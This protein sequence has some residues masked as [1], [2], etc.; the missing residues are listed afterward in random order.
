MQ[1]D[2]RFDDLVAS[3]AGFHNTWLV[4]LGVELGM[5]TH[6]R[7]AGP[8]GLTTVELAEATGCRPEA[9]EVWAWAADA[10]E[11]ATLEG[12]R[13]TVDENTAIVLLDEQ[14]PEFLGGQFVHSVTASLDWGGMLDFFRTGRPIADRPDR[15]RVS[16]ERLTVQ[17]IAVFFQEVLAELPQLVAD[18]ARG[19]RVVD[20]HCGGGRWLIAMARR[21]P[22]LQLVGVEFEPDSVMRARANVEAAGPV[23]PD[24][25][26]PGRVS[27]P[28][29]AGEY[30]LAYFQYAIHQ[31]ADPAAALRAAWGVAPT[32]RPDRRP[33]LAAA[34]ND[35]GVPDAPRRADRRRPARRAVPGHGARRRASSSA[36]GSPRPELPEPLLIDLPS[37]ASVFV[38]RER[39]TPRPPVPTR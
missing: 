13:L 34:V 32:R 19:G 14:R 20:I 15:Y 8:A 31:L 29:P 3:L 23:R 6:L 36:H 25:D 27:R 38:G 21:F 30:D 10:H 24:R 28:G 5:F 35:G 22:A 16:I 33:R 37:G 1:L 11:L 2:E 7:A 39:P 9:I 12:D 4:Y 17:D 26:P 18:L